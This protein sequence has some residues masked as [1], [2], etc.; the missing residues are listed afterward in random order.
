MEYFGEERKDAIEAANVQGSTALI[1]A[2]LK[3]HL[4]V[5]MLLAEVEGWNSLRC[6]GEGF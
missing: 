5:V 2:A 3:G 1:D 4:E 6:C